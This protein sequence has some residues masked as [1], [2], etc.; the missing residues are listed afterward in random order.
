[1]V[2]GDR[3][4]PSNHPIFR[5]TR[6]IRLRS[7]RS[8]RAVSQLRCAGVKAVCRDRATS[9]PYGVAE[10]RLRSDCLRFHVDRACR[11]RRGFCPMW[12]ESPTHRRN[13]TDRFFWV[14]AD[15][16]NSLRGGDI[17]AGSPVLIPRWAL[18]M[19]LDDLLPSR[20]SITSAH[21][22]IISDRECEKGQTACSIRSD[23]VVRLTLRLCSAHK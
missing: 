14:L 1:M 6:T 3:L 21:K 12:N 10:R 19:F 11:D 13:L 2:F 5:R 4:S 18:E 17:V 7:L 15:H 20:Q 16:R 22:R 23:F 8:S 9:M